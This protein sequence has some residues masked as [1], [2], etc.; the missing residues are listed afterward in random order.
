MPLDRLLF[1]LLAV[2]LIVLAGLI[3]RW[4]TRRTAAGIRTR[5]APPPHLT[6]ET[7]APIT[8]LNFSSP[9]CGTCHRVQKPLVDKISSQFADQ[10]VVVDVDALAQ[11]DLAGAYRVF[12]VP[13]TVILTGRH[14][15]DVNYGLASAETLDRQLRSALTSA[16][17]AAA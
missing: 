14:V 5:L 11:P 7:T 12:T 4:W 15:Q 1:V 16:G 6:T 8:L 3:V 17:S 13:S 10:V 9:H 2:T